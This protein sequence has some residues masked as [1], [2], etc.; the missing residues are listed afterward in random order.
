MD[1]GRPAGG[2]VSRAPPQS[3]HRHDYAGYNRQQ[4][5]GALHDVN[6]LCACSPGSQLD[7][8]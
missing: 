5:G 3:S 6:N 4:H 7:A 1:G 2:G 8:F